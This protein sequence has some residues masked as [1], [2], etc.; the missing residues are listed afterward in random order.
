MTEPVTLELKKV[1][2]KVLGT[3]EDPG[4]PYLF[5]DLY[6]FDLGERPDFVKAQVDADHDGDSDIRGGVLKATDGTQYGHT[7]WF[8]ENFKRCAG[9]YEADRG[10]AWFVG[11]YHFA[12]FQLDPVMQAEFYLKTMVTAG[13]GE[14]DIIPIIDVEFGNERHPNQRA[15]TQQIIDCI[16]GMAVHLKKLTGRRVMLYGRGSMRDRSISSKM[17]CDVVWNPAYT[18]TM[19]TNGLTGKLPNGRPAPWKLEDIVLWQYGGDGMGDDDVHHLPLEIKG[20][21]K[22]DMSVFIDGRAPYKPDL[23]RVRAML[24]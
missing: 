23:A 9:L 5:F 4:P 10:K 7:G 8:I 1:L 24:L 17:G 6:P 15:G 11:G 3:A 18:E 16:S 13:W 12:Q 14:R 21:G 22:V 19:V 20:F 2:N